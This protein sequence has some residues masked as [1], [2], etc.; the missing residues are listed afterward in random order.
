M[1]PLKFGSH[2]N[3]L[4]HVK[5]STLIFPGNPK[6]S[7]LDEFIPANFKIY[8]TIDF[9]RASKTSHNLQIIFE[10]FGTLFCTFKYCRQK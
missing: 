3:V 9:D 2:V 8:R 4:G 6:A 7:C 5:Y 1:I 10:T